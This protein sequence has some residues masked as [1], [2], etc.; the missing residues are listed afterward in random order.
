MMILKTTSSFSLLE[1]ILIITLMSVLAGLAFPQYTTVVERMQAKNAEK[2][3]L[4]LYGA[5][6][7]YYLD[8]KT[9]AVDLSE[10]DVEPPQNPCFETPVA[11]SPDND[12]DLCESED[13]IAEIERTQIST[14]DPKYIL[15][16]K[17]DMTVTCANPVPDHICSRLGF[18]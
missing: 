11:C 15:Q 14:N 16:I 4:D 7:R 8:N 13:S 5:Q 17:Q 10:L 9:F 1:I 6:Q 2:T 3:L 12:S 18:D